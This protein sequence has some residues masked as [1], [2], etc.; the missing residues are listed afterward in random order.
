MGRHGHEKD[1]LTCTHL[2]S[3]LSR[4]FL[5]YTI[6]RRIALGQKIPFV[7]QLLR[8]I[9]V[10]MAKSSFGPYHGLWLDDTPTKR[11]DVI[12]TPRMMTRA[13]GFIEIIQ[14]QK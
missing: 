10:T 8:N 4:D 9:C 12:P 13:L 1:G 6:L 7:T 5:F 2:R 3:I 11:I 14:V